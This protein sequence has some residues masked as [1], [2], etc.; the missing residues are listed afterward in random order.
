[1][2]IVICDIYVKL[3]GHN[4]GHIQNILRFLEKNPS[5]NEYIFLLN[6]EAKN[7]PSV[8]T[9]ASNVSIV[10]FTDEEF[11]PINSGMSI[12]KST[13]LIWKHIVRYVTD[14]KADKLVMMMLDMFQHTIG[15]SRLPCEV[16]GIMFNPYPRVIA[17]D[18]TLRAK[19]KSTITKA[20]KLFTTWWMCRN[21]QLKKV[22]IFNDLETLKTMNETLG[23]KV[24]TYLPDPVY[25]Y[26]VREGLDIREKYN[27]AADKKIILAFGFIDE[28]KNVVN[29]LKAMQ[30]LSQEE[31]SKT[32]LLIVGKIRPDY[33]K[34][35]A[36]ALVETKTNR[37]QLQI[38]LESRFVDD[39]EMEAF[40]GQSDIISVVYINFFSS[41][42]VIGLAARHNKPVLATKF[43]VVGDL[44]R[45]YELGLAVDGFNTS[46]MKDAM[47]DLL[48]NKN[49]YPKR[50]T[51]FVENHSSD[52][53]I[54]TLLEI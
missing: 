13:Q 12:V 39:D 53:F 52:S 50:A 33:E 28:K 26:P 23:T 17:Q 43:G 5:S 7:I 16:T 14:Y 44:T 21:T 25:D 20:R 45:K 15:S 1:M 8:K 37:P 54:K 4:L 18:T 47:Q 9:S 10:F 6:P 48:E 46:E 19:Q 3:I 40:V 34:S 42:G 32:C 31:A 22:F 27:I 38:A 24:F 51:D 30:Q 49:G 41:S 29:I 36:E 2:R 35:L 11:T